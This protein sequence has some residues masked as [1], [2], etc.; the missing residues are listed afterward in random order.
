MKRP[1]AALALITAAAVAGP[2]RADDATAVPIQAMYDKVTA[3]D[4][5]G[6]VAHLTE[7][8]VYVIVPAP[9]P[10]GAPGVSGREAIAGWWDGMHKDNG[11][12]EVQDLTV[13]GDRAIFRGLYFGDRLERIGMSPAEFEGTAVM[14]DG[15]VRL[16]A[17]VYSAD[18]EPRLRAAMAARAN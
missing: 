13:N 3:G 18:Y 14:R 8:A 12:F 17:V 2:A 11:R 9:E 15:K 10:W 6:A 5:A 1:L 16:L 4:I 7:D